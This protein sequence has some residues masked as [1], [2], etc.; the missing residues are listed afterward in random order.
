MDFLDCSKR[1][2]TGSTINDL[3]TGPEEIEKKIFYA[4]FPGKNVDGSSTGKKI[5]DCPSPGKKKI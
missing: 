1:I 4:S 2:S 5:F 3:G